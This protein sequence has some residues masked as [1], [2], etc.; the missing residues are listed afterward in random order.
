MNQGVRSCVK[1]PALAPVALSCAAAASLAGCGSAEEPPPAPEP[2]ASPQLSERPAGRLV[3]VG[4]EPEGLAADPRTGMIAVALRNPDRLVLVRGR[5]GRVARRVPLPESARH[6]QLAPGGRVLAPAERADLLAEVPLAGGRPATTAVGDFPHDAAEAGGRILVANEGDDTVTIVEGGRPVATLEAPQGP[7]GVAA[8]GSLAAVVGVRARRVALYDLA[9]RRQI[10][11]VEGG[12]GS[13]HVVADERHAYVADTEGE[14]ILVYRLRP[15][16]E[17]IDRANL[18]GSPYAL[19]LDRRR[20]ELWVTLTE[21]N[22]VVRLELSGGA[23]RRK[24]SYPTVRQPNS[25]AV[26]ERS[27]GVFVAG[28]EGSKL[29][30]LGS[31]VSR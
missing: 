4:T 15:E 10:G 23:P 8:A 29:Q 25:V 30:I 3:R 20:G 11:E 18:P 17:F 9:A 2:A 21:S 7:G 19:A 26:D 14:A 24:E 12:V 1:H 31:E 27:G 22:E 6:L 13:T 16:L 28:R 5:S